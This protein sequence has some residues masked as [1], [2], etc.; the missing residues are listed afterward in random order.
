LTDDA[1]LAR[2]L[3][4]RSLAT[5]KLPD[6][7]SLSATQRLSEPEALL[8]TVLFFDP[9]WLPVP[10]SLPEPDWLVLAQPETPEPV[11]Q[12]FQSAQRM[13]P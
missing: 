12:E 6:T 9:Q 13:T 10:Q 4:R 2:W 11:S 7:Q 8:E 1:P 3:Q 5:E